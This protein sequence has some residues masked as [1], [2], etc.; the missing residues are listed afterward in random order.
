MNGKGDGS[1]RGEGYG[2]TREEHICIGASSSTNC[3]HKSTLP[4]DRGSPAHF[5]LPIPPQ[6]TGGTKAEDTE[7]FKEAVR[8]AHE[9]L[10]NQYEEK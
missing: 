3:G 6:I 9:Q 1:G 2:M 10:Q 5:S 4:L 8:V 7:E